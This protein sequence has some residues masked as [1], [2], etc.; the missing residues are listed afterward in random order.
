M[1][2]ILKINTEMKI[3]LIVSNPRLTPPT[4]YLLFLLWFLLI[5]LLILR[6]DLLLGF[7]YGFLHTQS[8]SP[9]PLLTLP[10]LVPLDYP[11]HTQGRSS[12]WFCVWFSP[13]PELL[14]LPFTYS[15][16]SGS[17][18]LS[19]SYSGPIFFLVLC[20]VFSTPRVTPPTLY[21]L[22]LLGFLLIILL[23]L[24]ADLLLG[25]VYGFLHTQSYSPYPL[26]TLPPRVPLDYPPHTQ[27]RSSSSFCVWS[28]PAVCL[29]MRCGTAPSSV[30]GH[31]H[32]ET[33]RHRGHRGSTD[34]WVVA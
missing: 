9:Y 30:P 18:W 10:P 16:S 33:F 6:A 1:T 21:L 24:R 5:I 31:D 11:P 2:L 32:A 29:W 3:F 13:H 12:S 17:S 23:I 8:Y 25:F 26:L 14:P 22:F 4:L 34:E 7:V 19:S 28:A 20:M 15:S 27:G